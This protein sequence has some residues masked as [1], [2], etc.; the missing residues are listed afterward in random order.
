MEKDLEKI[1]RQKREATEEEDR[2]YRVEHE[3]KK[4]APTSAKEELSGLLEIQAGHGDRVRAAI[5]DR[6]LGEQVVRENNAVTRRITELRDII[7]QL[8]KY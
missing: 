7:K 4:L 1:K 8:E 5:R 2:L 6:Q 3:R